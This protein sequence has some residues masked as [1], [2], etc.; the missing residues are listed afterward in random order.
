MTSD[1]MKEAY[2]AISKLNLEELNKLSAE[3]NNT[4]NEK[5]ERFDELIVALDEILREIFVNYPNA[6]IPMILLPQLENVNIMG[7]LIIPKNFIQKCKMGD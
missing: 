4:I 5:K 7:D 3:I 2:K 1:N 6:Y